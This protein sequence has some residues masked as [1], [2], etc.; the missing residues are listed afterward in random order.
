MESQL[1]FGTMPKSGLLIEIRTMF[2]LAGS[3]HVKDLFLLF[4]KLRLIKQKVTIAYLGLTIHTKY[5]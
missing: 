4:T 5:V 2:W 3:L 1:K